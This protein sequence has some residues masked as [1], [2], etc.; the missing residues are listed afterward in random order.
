MLSSAY[1]VIVVLEGAVWAGFPSV[2][3][4]L[5]GVSLWLSGPPFISA[6]STLVVGGNLVP[7]RGKKE[8]RG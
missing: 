8:K 1:R 2:C 3:T 4:I 5:V 7:V 6:Y